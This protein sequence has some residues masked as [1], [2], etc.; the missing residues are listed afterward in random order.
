MI[1]CSGKISLTAQRGCVD[2]CWKRA[3]SRYHTQ[4]VSVTPMSVIGV[5]RWR[6][7]WEIHSRNH[8]R[9]FGQLENLNQLEQNFRCLCWSIKCTG[10]LDRPEFGCGL[11]WLWFRLIQF[12]WPLNLPS[13]RVVACQS[14]SITT[15]HDCCGPLCISLLR[16]IRCLLWLQ[17]PEQLPW[18]SASN[19][20]SSTFFTHYCCWIKCSHVNKHCIIYITII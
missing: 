11:L 17:M 9:S 16:V 15:Q 18:P 1:L 14:L 12:Y 13:N 20:L 2:I 10:E 5:A 6:Q 19:S 8:S 3:C 4:L 7:R